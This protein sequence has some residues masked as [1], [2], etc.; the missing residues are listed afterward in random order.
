MEYTTLAQIMVR[1][2][3]K[4]KF[5]LWKLHVQE[6]EYLDLKDTLSAAYIRGNLEMYTREAAIFYAEWWRREYNGGTPS[7]ER[8]ARAAG[9]ERS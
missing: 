2:G 3:G 4:I 8:V 5:P 6:Q 9:I 1:N 7:K